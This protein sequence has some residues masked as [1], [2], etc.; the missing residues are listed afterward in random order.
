MCPYPTGPALDLS[1]LERK[2]VTERTLVKVQCGKQ[3]KEAA[4][5]EISAWVL[6]RAE[7]I[8]ELQKQSGK[9]S[10]EEAA[11][12]ERRA[13]TEAL[14]DSEV[15]CSKVVDSVVKIF[16]LEQ[17]LKQATSHIVLKGNEFAGIRAKA[18]DAVCAVDVGTA[19]ASAVDEHQRLITSVCDGLSGQVTTGRRIDVMHRVI[20]MVYASSISVA[21]AI[22]EC[23]R[24]S[25]KQLEQT[26]WD[27]DENLSPVAASAPGDVKF[28]P[29]SEQLGDA[30]VRIL[31]HDKSIKEWWKVHSN[32]LP[33][34]ESKRRN[35]AQLREV[36]HE[37]IE[38]GSSTDKEAHGK[39]NFLFLNNSRKV[40]VNEKN[41]LYDDEVTISFKPLIVISYQSQR[42]EDMLEL[43]Q[44]LLDVAYLVGSGLDMPAGGGEGGVGQESPGWRD[45]WARLADL[46]KVVIFHLH[47]DFYNSA[48]CRSEF[49]YILDKKPEATLPVTLDREPMPRGFALGLSTINQILAYNVPS[50]AVSRILTALENM[51]PLRVPVPRPPRVQQEF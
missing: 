8:A 30:F 26:V 20:A 50:E 29:F 22:Q 37:A 49:N 47:N 33:P 2:V 4:S 15:D 27:T 39:E 19:V 35:L 24:E 31:V 44:Q 23:V 21:E 18:L 43:R 11:A 14:H 42:V 1:E 9:M 6:Q 5:E 36:I 38:E 48:T 51:A 16:M 3:V 17:E 46:A 34:K 45:F 32:K 40:I 7:L 10:Q 12:L 25:N 28:N 13:V 41:T